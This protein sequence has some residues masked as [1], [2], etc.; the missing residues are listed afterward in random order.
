MRNDELK[1]IE[2]A[3]ELL[4]KVFC[5]EGPTKDELEEDA[6][7]KTYDI[8]CDFFESNVEGIILDEKCTNKKSFVDGYFELSQ[9]G[10]TILVELKYQNKSH[11]IFYANEQL[12]E[13]RSSIYKNGKWNE[14]FNKMINR[15]KNKVN[16]LEIA[17]AMKCTKEDQEK[18]DYFNEL[19]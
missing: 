14:S 9:L 5:G 19:F 8:L 1:K 11:T 15:L 4:H 18:T 16:S 2:E 17:R 10:K 6:N 13:K 12:I 7:K 3:V